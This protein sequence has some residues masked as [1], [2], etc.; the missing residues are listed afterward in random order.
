MADAQDFVNN[1]LNGDD[2]PSSYVDW[3]GKKEDVGPLARIRFGVRIHTTDEEVIAQNAKEDGTVTD[4]AF[5]KQ[6]VEDAHWLEE[7]MAILLREMGLYVQ[8]EGHGESG[9]YVGSAWIL[10]S[11][12]Q[13]QQVYVAKK[14]LSL[15]GDLPSTT[16]GTL[17]K[18]FY[19]S[20]TKLYRN[21]NQEIGAKYLDVTVEFTSTDALAEWFKLNIVESEDADDPESFVQ[22][23]L[24]RMTGRLMIEFNAIRP[25]FP[26]APKNF[27]RENADGLILF[28]HNRASEMREIMRQMHAYNREREDRNK[29]PMNTYRYK[30]PNPHGHVLARAFLEKAGANAETIAWAEKTNAPIW[31]YM[32]V[33]E[34]NAYLRY[35]YPQIKIREA[36][37]ADD[38]E[39]Y[40]DRVTGWIDTFIHAGLVPD[41]SPA[42]S[43]QFWKRYECDGTN[44]TI[45]VHVR[46]PLWILVMRTHP[47]TGAG[48]LNLPFT[49]NE[50]DT[51]GMVT[52]FRALDRLLT[53][54]RT[55][56]RGDWPAV[57]Q[58]LYDMEKQN[59]RD[60]KLK[61]SGRRKLN[62]ADADDPPA[63][64]NR[65]LDKVSPEP[66]FRCGADLTQ[67]FTVVRHYVSKSSEADLT[68]EGHYDPQEG[69]FTND[70]PYSSGFLDA[71]SQYDLPE[72]CDI[73]KQCGGSTAKPDSLRNESVEDEPEVDPQAYADQIH[74]LAQ[75][76]YEIQEY[77]LFVNRIHIWGRWVVLGGGAYWATET[78]ASEKRL[79]ADYFNRQIDS[80][81]AKLGITRYHIK[82]GETTIGD[83]VWFQLALPKDQLEQESWQPFIRNTAWPEPDHETWLPE[84]QE[85]APDEA[86]EPELN[87]ERHTADLDLPALMERLGFKAVHFK[88]SG[89]T[90]WEKVIGPRCWNVSRA[91]GQNVNVRCHASF[92]T[93]QNWID[94]VNFTCSV[95]ELAGRLAD[96]IKPTVESVDPDDPAVN[97]ER[98]TADLDI[99]AVMAKLGFTDSRTMGATWDGWTKQVGNVKWG[100]WPSSTTNIYGVTRYERPAKFVQVGRGRRYGQWSDKGHFTCHVSE[101][102]QQ[103]REEGALHPPPVAEALDP[104]DPEHYLATTPPL[105]AIKSDEQEYG[106]NYL[107]YDVYKR[108]V[109]RISVD[110]NKHWNWVT[111]NRRYLKLSDEAY[112]NSFNSQNELLLAAAPF[113]VEPVGESLAVPDPDDPSVNVDRH[114]AAMAPG[115]VLAELGFNERW[116]SWNCADPNYMW[117]EKFDHKT[118]FKWTVIRKSD[119][120]PHV[121]DVSVYKMR[122]TPG[123]PL[124]DWQQIGGFNTHVGNLKKKLQRA[125]RMKWLVPGDDRIW[126]QNVRRLGETDEGDPE[127]YIKSL[128][129][130]IKAF[131]IADSTD[132]EG[133]KAEFNAADWF[134]KA[135]LEQL[136]ALAKQE[137]QSSYDADAVG[138]YFFDTQLKDWY[139]NYR[140]GGFEVYIDEDSVKLW[141]EHNRPDWYAYLWPGEVLEVLDPD[142][143]E[144]NI[145]AHM[146]HVEKTEAD[147]LESAIANALLMFGHRVSNVDDAKRADELAVEIAT[148]W[149]E[150]AGYPNG[151]DEYDHIVSALS[152]RAGELFPGDWEDYP[153]TLRPPVQEAAVDRRILNVIR[154]TTEHFGHAFM[155][156]DCG[157]FAIAL[158][159]FLTE[160]GVPA[161]YLV[162]YG[163]HYE[164]FDHVAVLVNGVAYDG[165]GVYNKKTGQGYDEWK[166]E[167]YDIE[168]EEFPNDDNSVAAICKYTDPDAVFAHGSDADKTLAFM[169][170]VPFGNV[171][172]QE[173]AED[174]TDWTAFLEPVVEAGMLPNS[175]AIK[176]QTR[177]NPEANERIYYH[178]V[179][180]DEFSQQGE[181]AEVMRC[182]QKIADIV[183]ATNMR[184]GS[185]IRDLARD[186]NLDASLEESVDGVDDPDD[187]AMAVNTYTQDL[188]ADPDKAATIN[189][190]PHGEAEAELEVLGFTPSWIAGKNTIFG[191][192][193]IPNF[194]SKPYRSAHGGSSK[195]LYV[196]IIPE[197]KDAAISVRTRSMSIPVALKPRSMAHIVTIIKDVDAAVQRAADNGLTKEQEIDAIVGV[198][199]HHRQ[200]CR[201]S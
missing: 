99:N 63:D 97:I 28:Q 95:N 82:S 37:D 143:P 87:V 43:N 190:H 15:D 132:D 166:K 1:A 67:P 175:A 8:G 147:A 168:Y 161:V 26:D 108:P 117:W 116:P 189:K 16:D 139:A 164:M 23:F 111:V 194:W 77:G 137:F 144:P 131:C 109:G 195:L 151:S 184:Y 182:L 83:N 73:C 94:P 5:W 133:Q 165:E 88:H 21:V 122:I 89:T 155:S 6:I 105:T 65:L 52:Q 101:L 124:H 45:F 176:Y 156:G 178:F 41:P 163:S 10:A 130:P 50:K 47:T 169:R 60:R 114:V 31:F 173:G 9:E 158:V 93:P 100:V 18:Y 186:P 51:A 53:Q 197:G 148:Y 54:C 34:F 80:F 183:S 146:Q 84:A 29:T 17:W 120:E 13:E 180:M 91:D 57:D 152:N 170:T 71:I 142:A 136:I 110:V 35:V 103:L 11:L 59:E 58:E 30:V 115:P 134:E 55:R 150:A 46:P 179:E 85:A 68:L 24:P 174:V 154:A 127:H 64:V 74:N 149:A 90:Y 27:F 79:K 48:Q 56:A 112:I 121:M 162:E 75:I 199:D 128:P 172:V 125:F 44:F 167:D 36:E 106:D 32:S 119:D 141:I 2:D 138:E 86:D 192:P 191:E 92:G 159:R 49:F 96:V 3:L 135:T 201:P 66:C 22:H 118:G 129:I 157:N 98:H 160:K 33:D 7:N 4:E 113:V 185:A 188:V 12:P 140:G 171:P 181:D 42:H 69:V 78:A 153:N 19:D 145:Q 193:E 81:M 25:H 104:D 38:P 76:T 187:A 20:T 40:L 123:A 62:E 126:G 198:L 61:L 200:W 177:N 196:K 70:E 102:E 107:V 39:G 72:D 14:I